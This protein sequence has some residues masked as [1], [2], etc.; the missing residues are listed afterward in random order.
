MDY[1]KHY[2]NLIE[3][4]KHR[5]LEGY[6][7]KHHILPKCIGGND[8]K[9]N[10]AILTPEEHYVAHQ[11]LI[12]MY[13]GNRD[14]LYAVQLMSTHHTTNRTNNKLF[15]WIRKQ[16]AIDMSIRSKQWILDNGHPRGM[17]G[18]HHD[19]NNIEK[20]A[21]GLKKSAIEKRIEVFLYDLTGMF[22][23]KYNS[24]MECAAFLQTTP[25]NVKYTADGKF[26]RCKEY[27]IRYEYFDNI[28]PYKKSNPQQGKKKTPEH[29]M[30]MKESFKY[31]RKRT[32]EENEHHSQKMKEYHARKKNK[33]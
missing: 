31:R 28:P 29:I 26:G 21:R 9:D 19:P 30:A 3:R 6:V 15:G 17:L 4:S 20:M 25:S 24:I 1:K 12:K 33:L 27:Q 7:E 8:D 32:P 22:I 18:K 5:I 14:L 2:N 11:L 10:I 16:M 13:P 23:C